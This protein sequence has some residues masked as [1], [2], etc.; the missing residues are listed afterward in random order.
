[1]NLLV[2]FADSEEDHH[3]GIYQ[4]ASWVYDGLRN[5]RLDGFNVDGDF[6]PARTCNATYGTSSIE[7]LRKKLPSKKIE[8][9]FDSGKHCYWKALDKEGMQ[10]AMRLGL[11][12]QAYPK[13]MLEN[14]SEA[15]CSVDPMKRK[16]IINIPGVNN[17]ETSTDIFKVDISKSL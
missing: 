10:K 9:H 11:R 3:G 2:S 13:P 17:S 5:S 6:I 16:G 15:N 14:M 8:P 7:K 12:S 1:M 4:S